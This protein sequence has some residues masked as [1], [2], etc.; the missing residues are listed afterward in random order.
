MPMCL[1]LAKQIQQLTELECAETSTTHPLL[2]LIATHAS[3][4]KLD[5]LNNKGL[6]V[7]SVAFVEYRVVNHLYF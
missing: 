5:S 4:G 7:V 1:A 6:F 3:D 2:S